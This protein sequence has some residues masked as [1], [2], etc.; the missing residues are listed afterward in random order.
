MIYDLH[1]HS[2]ASDGILRPAELVSR[3]KTQGVSHLALTDHDT[4]S[5]LD[6]AEE[7]ARRNDIQF[8]P[9][10]ELSTQWKDQGVHIVGLNVDRNDTVLRKAVDRQYEI[11][12]ARAQV[13]AERLADE[14]IPN[15]LQGAQS[16][17]NGEVV[18]RPHFA[19]HLIAEGVVKDMSEAFRSY[20]GTGK[21]G[22]V[23]NVWLDLEAVTEAISH[24]GGVA[25]LAHPTKYKLTRHKLVSLV[26]DFKACGGQAIEVISGD[27]KINDTYKMKLIAKQLGMHASCGSDFHSPDQNWQELG[28][29]GLLPADCSPVWQLWQ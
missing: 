10:I 3:A 27:Q 14:G 23:P 8:I 1:S 2:N 18:G 28:V 19:Q 4:L 11:R 5:G 13:I 9:G 17:A 21:A 12:Q 26:A 25:V 6:E 29:C 24:G 7:S 22:D 16:F 15:T 20:L